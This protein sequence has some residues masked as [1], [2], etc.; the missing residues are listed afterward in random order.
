[1]P[2]LFVWCGRETIDHRLVVQK[3]NVVLQPPLLKSST[4]VCT[5]LSVQEHSLVKMS[6]FSLMLMIMLIM[7]WLWAYG[8]ANAYANDSA[9]DYTYTK[10]NACD[11]ANTSV[12]V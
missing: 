12:N 3:A 2:L 7:F 6:A 9:N 4:I 5:Y 1:M 10:V 8:Y 11:Y